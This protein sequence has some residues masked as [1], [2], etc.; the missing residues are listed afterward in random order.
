M[1]VIVELCGSNDNNIIAVQ[2]LPKLSSGQR[3][4]IIGNTFQK[5]LY[6]VSAGK[7]TGPFVSGK[8]A[9]LEISWF[10]AWLG[11]R[12][13]LLV[14]DQRPRLRT[15]ELSAEAVAQLADGRQIPIATD[16]TVSYMLKVTDAKALAEAAAAA[17]VGNVIDELEEKLTN[18][19]NTELR[20]AL[21]Q[22]D[23]PFSFYDLSSAAEA[24][25]SALFHRMRGVIPGV[26]VEAPH[27]TVEVV[28]LSDLTMQMN[29]DIEDA[30]N[31]RL[32][33]ADVACEALSNYYNGATNVRR[34]MISLI[35][36][37][38]QA[39]PGSGA[40]ELQAALPAFERLV[41]QFGSEATL[42]MA[43]QLV[44]GAVGRGKNLLLGGKQ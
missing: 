27:V 41:A 36:S 34:E 7:V 10:N 30:R 21:R 23:V 43:E 18:A 25:E 38:L 2:E 33:L 5:A 4:R 31:M 17:T 22:L 16:V 37:Y 8:R 35:G 28:N 19:V 1:A 3:L 14:I 44:G 13:L 11:S 15:L 24:V 12:A 39:N 9:D 20:T 29:R 26:F 42:Q 6:I 40:A 32:K